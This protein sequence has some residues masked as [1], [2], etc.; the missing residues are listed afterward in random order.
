MIERKGKT[1]RKKEKR[2]K[3]EWKE[4]GITN[5]ICR[6]DP[7]LC[8]C[9][10][11]P[12]LRTVER[13][14]N[15]TSYHKEMQFIYHTDKLWRKPIRYKERVQKLMIDT[16]RACGGGRPAGIVRRRRPA[17]LPAS[18]SR[19]RLLRSSEHESGKLKTAS[20]SDATITRARITRPRS[21]TV[22]ERR[23]GHASRMDKC[24]NNGAR[25]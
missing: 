25:P 10:H 17:P 13:E 3:K 5:K 4:R 21:Y 20:L 22:P 8:A 18:F 2:R 24:R 12:I 6:R 16:R 23:G 14:I 15:N 1:I 11:A 9:Y 19:V 7:T